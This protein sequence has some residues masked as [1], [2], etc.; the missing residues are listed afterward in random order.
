[1]A[2][3]YRHLDDPG[4]FEPHQGRQKAVQSPI[5]LY[6]LQHVGSHH[7]QGA[8]GVIDIFAGQPVTNKVADPAADFLGKRILPVFAASR[9]P[10]RTG[11]T[12]RAALVYRQGRSADRR[13]W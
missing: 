1:M 11:R 3:V 7:L 2:V 9:S 12:A 6:V 4:P 5:H 13:P 10:C 8:A